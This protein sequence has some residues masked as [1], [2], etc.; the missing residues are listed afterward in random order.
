MKLEKL[1]EKHIIHLFNHFSQKE[2][3]PRLKKG[4]KLWLDLSNF[5][6]KGFQKNKL[7]FNK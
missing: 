3:W 7:T 5:D 6:E 1:E 4:Y 2:E